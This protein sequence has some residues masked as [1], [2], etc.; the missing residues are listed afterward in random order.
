MWSV[1]GGTG[2]SSSAGSTGISAGAQS[3]S[4]GLI[5]LKLW[6]D[7]FTI[8]DGEMRRYSD[9]GSREFL[10]TI[11]RG[12]IPREIRQEFPNGE[13]RLDMEDHHHEEYIPTRPKVRAFTGKG[14]K[15]GSPSPATVGMTVTN[16]PADQAANESQARSSLNLD[17]SRPLTSLQIRLA[18]GNNIREQFNMTHTIGDL[19][20]FITTYV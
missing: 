8:N 9:P 7:G 10:A 2:A 18:D 15:L 11:K 5:T 17:T 1:L 16:D 13:V 14:H 6:R 20:R 19:R 3:N 4:G 12:E